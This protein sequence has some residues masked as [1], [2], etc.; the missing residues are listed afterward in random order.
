MFSRTT[1]IV[2]AAGAI[3]SLT[4]FAIVFALDP[5]NFCKALNGGIRLHKPFTIRYNDALIKIFY[6]QYRFFVDLLERF[7]MESL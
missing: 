3:G 1:K 6:I 2:L 5:V 4:P 7:Y